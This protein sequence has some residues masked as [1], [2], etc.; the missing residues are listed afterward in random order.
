MKE[1]D[2]QAAIFNQR[3]Y[4]LAFCPSGEGEKPESLISIDKENVALSCFKQSERDPSV[5]IIRVFEC[6]GNKADARIEIPVAGVFARISLAPFE[7]KTFRL[8]GGE[9]TECDMLEGAVPLEN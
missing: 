3:A 8:S 7:I 2:R 5:S 6:Q 9:L 1:V 4:G